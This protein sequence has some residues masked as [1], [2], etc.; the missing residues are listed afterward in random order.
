MRLFLPG[1][2]PSRSTDQHGSSRQG[3][4]AHHSSSWTK[5]RRAEARQVRA[6]SLE[7]ELVTSAG[8]VPRAALSARRLW[9]KGSGSSSTDGWRTRCGARRRAAQARR[10]G[11][12]DSAGDGGVGGQNVAEGVAGRFSEIVK[13]LR[14]LG[15]D[16]AIVSGT[17]CEVKPPGDRTGCNHFCRGVSCRE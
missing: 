1:Q 12:N 8:A 4:Q 15:L 10:Q 2:P 7:L 14:A 13:L 16:H 17:R 9:Q 11:A 6:P 5:N 3:G